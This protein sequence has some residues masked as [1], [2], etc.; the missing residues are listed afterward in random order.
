MDGAPECPVCLRPL[1]RHI[2]CSR[3]W[4]MIPSRR[5]QAML[6]FLWN[7]GRPR[8]GFEEARENFAAQVVAIATS[9]AANLR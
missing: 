1:E 2:F 5:G 6:W 3:H 4:Q 7:N 9:R 8:P